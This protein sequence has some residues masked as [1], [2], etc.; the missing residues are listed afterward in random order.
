MHP[1]HMFS[2]END[3]IHN[4][5]NDKHFGVFSMSCACIGFSGPCNNPLVWMLL[6]SQFADEQLRHREVV[7]HTYRSAYGEG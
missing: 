2:V 4:D 3:S 1:P 5:D 7:A 6:F